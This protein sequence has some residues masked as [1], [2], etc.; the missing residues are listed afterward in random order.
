M[1]LSKLFLISTTIIT[2]Q[3]CVGAAIVG[4]VGG[5]NVA[6]DNRSVGQQIDDQAIE[7]AAYDAINK[8]D[9]LKEQTHIQITS[10]NGSVLIAGQVPSQQLKELAVGKISAVKNVKRI[11]NQ[12]RISNVSSFSTRTNDTWLTSKVKTNLFQSDEVQATNIKVVTE[13][14]EVFL[15]GVIARSQA[16]KAVDIA[17][18]VSGVNRVFKAFEYID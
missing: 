12:L 1:R 3:G 14:G 8:I 17:R 11:H 9:I 13:N 18:N 6:G 7:F 10:V 15:L 2:L 16:D 5:A 4:V